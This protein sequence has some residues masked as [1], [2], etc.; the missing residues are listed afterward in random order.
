MGDSENIHGTFSAEVT[1]KRSWR[2]SS[3]FKSM[4]AARPWLSYLTM[5]VMAA[6]MLYQSQRDTNA[7]NNVTNTELA[8]GQKTIREDITARKVIVDAQFSEIK[9]EMVTE[10]VFQAR[11]DAINQRMDWQD[12]MLTQILEHQSK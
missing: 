8:A 2:D 12:R 10:K 4:E 9:G 6:F 5:I 11:I 3:F 7:Q 1:E